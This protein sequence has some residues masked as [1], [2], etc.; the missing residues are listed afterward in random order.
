MLRPARQPGM[1]ECVVITTI[2][3]Y[4]LPSVISAAVEWKIL[5]WLHILAPLGMRGT[6]MEEGTKMSLGSLPPAGST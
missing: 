6:G 3:S 1:N 4:T 5:L 2:V